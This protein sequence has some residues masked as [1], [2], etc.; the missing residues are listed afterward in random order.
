MNVNNVFFCFYIFRFLFRSGNFEQPSDRF[1]NTT[2]E[3]LP[4][5]GNTSLISA[6]LPF[7][8]TKDGF[9]VVGSFNNIGIA[10]GVI[11]SKIGK[12]KELRLHVNSDSQNWVILREVSGEKAA[13]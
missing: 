5:S 12:L 2:V 3:V 1:Y 8:V 4:A 6:A 11:D 13:C 10:D 7:N 9:L